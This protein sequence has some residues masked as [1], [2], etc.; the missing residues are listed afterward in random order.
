MA[1]YHIIACNVLW[2]EICHFSSLSKNRFTFNF[3]PQGLHDTPETLRSELQ[4]AINDS[5]EDSEAILIGYGLCSNGLAGV[6]AK[7][8]KLVAFRA[9]DCITCL[10]GSKE[11]YA[12]Y[13]NEHPGTYWYSPGWI[14]TGHQ[15]G[16][17]RVERLRASYAEKY[18]EENADYLMEM[19]QGWFKKYSRAAYIDM[20][21]TEDRDYINYTKECADYLKWEYDELKGSSR[22]IREILDGNWNNDDFLVVNPGQTIKASN[23]ST[24]IAT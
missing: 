3:L 7:T 19:E 21:I 11:R 2:R 20:G 24:I 9:H 15:P 13:F 16:K 4:K 8:T 22:L 23:D 18:G 5:P 14:E 6:T 12:E 17:E 1:K 10:I